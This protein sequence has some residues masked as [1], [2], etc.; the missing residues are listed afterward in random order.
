MAIIL[1]DRNRFTEFFFTGR[2]LGKF[3]VNW[4]LKFPVL[5]YAATL[6]CE[7]I[8]VTKQVINNKLQRS[9]A[10][11]VVGFLIIK[12]RKVYCQVSQ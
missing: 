11:G 5:A 6:L 2:F 8:N 4:L 3:A 7:N 10:K 12:L 9:V 1:S